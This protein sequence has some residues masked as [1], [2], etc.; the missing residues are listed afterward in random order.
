MMLFMILFKNFDYMFLK[1]INYNCKAQY[2]PFELGSGSHKKPL[3]SL[4]NSL[5]QSE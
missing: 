3:K 4:E 2:F 1:L 5:T